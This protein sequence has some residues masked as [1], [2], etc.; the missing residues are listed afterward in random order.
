MSVKS[1]LIA[2]WGQINRGGTLRRRYGKKRIR[3][4][5]KATVHRHI[6]RLRKEG[7]LKTQAEVVAEAAASSETTEAPSEP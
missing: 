5:A 6:D 1:D 3:R 4:M 2:L 7:K